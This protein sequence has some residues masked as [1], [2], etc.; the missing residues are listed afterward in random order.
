MQRQG[1]LVTDPATIADGVHFGLEASA[2]HAVPRLSSSALQKLAVSPATFWRGSW[3]DPDRAEEA[4]EQTKAQ[5]IGQAYHLARLQPELLETRFVREIDRADLDP[6]GAVWNGTEIGKA[7]AELGETKSKAGELVADQ[8]ARLEAAGFTGAIW[9]LAYARW[10]ETVGDRTPLPAKVWDEIAT[11]MERI[12]ATG[13]IAAL[14]SDGEAEVSIF[15]HD[16]DGLPMK[17]RLDY[18][19]PGA[20]ADLKTFDNSRGKVL[21]QALAD[22]FRFNRYY[23]Q[24]AVYRDAVE[25]VRVGG[26]EIVGVAT[27]AQRALVAAIR[28][29]PAELACWYV[30]QEKG[31]TP[32][33]LARRFK[34]HDVPINIRAQTAGLSDERLAHVEATSARATQIF[35]RAEMDVRRAKRQFVRH[36]Q[37]YEPG[38]PWFPIEPLGTIDDADFHPTWLEGRYE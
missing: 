37:V 23:M 6:D 32:N 14:L 24:A 5:A 3:L 34:F 36:S 16:E 12:R 8:G 33:L 22:A 1:A 26:L 19:R 25:Q 17:A 9:P 21:D 30:F 11:D 29:C 10:E 4:D 31:G 28:I 20:W 15:W 7:L 35:T 38:R 2:Y 18:L 13:D 27:D